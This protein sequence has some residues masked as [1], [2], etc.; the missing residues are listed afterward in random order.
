MAA[1][2]T[3]GWWLEMPRN[4]VL[5]AARHVRQLLHAAAGRGQALPDGQLGDAVEDEEVRGL[6][7][8][9][10]EAPVDLRGHGPVHVV[11]LVDD[12]HALAP[13][14]EGG[15]DD[16]LA[17]PVL[18]AGG[19]VD[20]VQAGVHR[21][22]DGGHALLERHGA[23]GQVADPQDRR[24]ETRPSEFASRL[25]GWRHSQGLRTSPA[26]Q[27]LPGTRLGTQRKNCPGLSHVPR[28]ACNP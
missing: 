13:A 17:V 23:V 16:L 2:S 28:V 21:A 22:A 12:E 24:P 19:G 25:K 27:H 6:Q 10:P 20:D 26:T 11:D 14:L 4:R 7:P 5:P 9:P 18:V 1:R 15:P 3:S 8:Q